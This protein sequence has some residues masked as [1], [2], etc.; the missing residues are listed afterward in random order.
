MCLGRISVLPPWPPRSC[1]LAEFEG[2]CSPNATPRCC[3]HGHVR[4]AS[5]IDG[6]SHGVDQVAADSEVAHLHLAQGV[7]EHVG[8]LDICKRRQS[9]AWGHSSISLP[10]GG[11]E[12]PRPPW[13][14]LK[15]H[16]K[17]NCH[18][19]H[20]TNYTRIEHDLLKKRRKNTKAK[21]KGGK[22]T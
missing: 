17:R 19:L 11:L 18:P 7:D 10:P 8:G 14:A 15:T 5:G 13:L 4:F 9:G 2:T 1:F 21:K 16:P 22:A 6:F 12:P 20:N 3:T